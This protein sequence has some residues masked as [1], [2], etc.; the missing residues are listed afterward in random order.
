MSHLSSRGRNP[1]IPQIPGPL[2][3]AGSYLKPWEPPAAF[4]T[5]PT[6]L[7]LSHKHI[8]TYIRCVLLVTHYAILL[9]IGTNYISKAS[10]GCHII[11]VH[12]Q[13]L[14][15]CPTL[16]DPMDYIACQAPLSLGFPRQEYWSGLPCPPAGGLPNPEIEP[17]SLTLQADSLP[18]SHWGSPIFPLA[19]G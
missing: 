11:Y 4:S 18:L 9:I 5:C 6:A 8:I 15:S 10:Q 19:H 17:G 12:A 13:S 3:R 1:A 16:C 14:Q 2:W 7:S